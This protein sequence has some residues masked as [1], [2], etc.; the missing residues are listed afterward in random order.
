M[1]REKTTGMGISAT[2]ITCIWNK[3]KV[4][5]LNLNKNEREVVYSQI[6]QDMEKSR[7]VIDL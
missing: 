6:A 1:K 5:S 7:D 3:V 2:D 4:N